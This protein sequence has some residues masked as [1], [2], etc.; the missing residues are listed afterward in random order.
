MKISLSDNAVLELL[1]QRLAETRL[2]HNQT[3]AELAAQ[4]GVSK[5]TLVRMEAGKSVQLI[6]LIRVLRS[7]Q[8]LENL[9][10]LIPEQQSSPLDMLKL[11]GKKRQR[12]SRKKDKVTGKPGW[13]WG[14]EQ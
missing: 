13:A 1:G 5:S 3:Q 14:D 8:L 9:D 10:L 12:A 2:L 6:N 4:A 11:Q 7:M